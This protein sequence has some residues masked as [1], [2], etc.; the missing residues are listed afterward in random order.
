[1]LGVVRLGGIEAH[2]THQDGAQRDYRGRIDSA[3]GM[4]NFY[5]LFRVVDEFVWNV[6]KNIARLAV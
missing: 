1:M 6:F 3:M 4:A 5:R 2:R